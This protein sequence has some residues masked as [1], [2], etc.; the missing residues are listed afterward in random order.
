MGWMEQVRIGCEERVL[1]ELNRIERRPGHASSLP[2]HLVT[3]ID[4]EDAA[5]FFL[6]RKGYTVVARRWSAG[7]LP[8]D[9]D[10]IAWHGPLLCIIEVKTAPH[11][12]S[13]R[14]R[15]PSTRTS[16]RPSAAWLA[17]TCANYRRR[18][19]RRSASMCSASILCREKRRS[20][21]ISKHR[22]G[23]A[24]GGITKIDSQRS[25]NSYSFASSNSSCQGHLDGLKP[26]LVG[27][28]RI[29][30]EA[31]KLRHVTMKV[32]EAHRQRSTSGYFS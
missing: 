8:G 30:R 14:P 23:G 18:Q 19:L 9:I 11:T 21:T 6:R 13:P 15:L 5:F 31:G 22:S 10:L 4:G 32:G 12:T 7:N 20:S 25:E 28:G 3:G 17:N 27:L 2:A 29:I 26:R 1:A 24:S 16:A